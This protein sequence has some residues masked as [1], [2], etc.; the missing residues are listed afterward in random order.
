[1]FAV[2]TLTGCPPNY[3]QC[4]NDD[5]C[6]ADGEGN[7]ITFVCVAGTCM[8]CAA[9]ADCQS[10][11][12]CRQNTC[13]PKPECASNSDCSSP[14]ICRAEKCVPECESSSDCGSGLKCEA[15]RCVP[16]VECSAD[17]DCAEGKTC[18]ASGE[19]EAPAAPECSVDTIYFEF[20]SYSLSDSSRSTLESNATCVKEKGSMVRLQGHADERGTE[21]YN[22]ALGEK[23]ADSVRKFMKQLGVSDSK[24]KVISYGEERPASSGSDEASWQQNRRVEFELSE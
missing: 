3:P 8:E 13:V 20:D 7:P 11:F 21:E 1:M 17:S 19:C 24:M 15:Q 22:L 4:K 6:K 14:L 10:G 18:N 23:R 2:F 12:I 5:H 16:D 9:D